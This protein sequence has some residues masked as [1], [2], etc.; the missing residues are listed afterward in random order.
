VKST[1]IPNGFM[2]IGRLGGNVLIDFDD[3]G[4]VSSEPLPVSVANWP[5][6]VVA[7]GVIRPDLLVLVHSVKG[8]EGMLIKRLQ[9][10]RMAHEGKEIMVRDV[11]R[12]GAL[13]ITAENVRKEY[14]KEMEAKEKTEC[15]TK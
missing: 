3:N 4:K 9:V 5:D 8:D 11:V 12:A 6:A 14:L 7:N 15:E 13:N 10:C 1:D 2:V